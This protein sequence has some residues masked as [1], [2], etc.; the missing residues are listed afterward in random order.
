MSSFH[1]QLFPLLCATREHAGAIA[2]EIKHPLEVS[3]ISVDEVY[4]V[5][6]HE[7]VVRLSASVRCLLTD[8]AQGSPTIPRINLHRFQRTCFTFFT[9]TSPWNIL[10]KREFGTCTNRA[11]GTDQATQCLEL[12]KDV[13]TAASSHQLLRIVLIL[14]R[15]LPNMFVLSTQKTGVPVTLMYSARLETLASM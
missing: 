2:K 12:T 8:M 3:W 14:T 9:A 5:R 11:A 7:Y 15:V 1:Q 10:Q 13:G 6:L 4:V